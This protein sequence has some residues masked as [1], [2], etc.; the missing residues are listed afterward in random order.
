MNTLEYTAEATLG[1]IFALNQ[2]VMNITYKMDS[3]HLSM[4]IEMHTAA[5]YK[6]IDDKLHTHSEYDSEWSDKLREWE[7]KEY[8]KSCGTSRF[9][10]DT[11]IIIILY[12]QDS[13]DKLEEFIVELYKYFNMD[14]SPY[15]ETYAYIN[16]TKFINIKDI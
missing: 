15:N 12:F 1:Y 16:Y 10:G 11:A 13:K 3:F 5:D 4:Y 9:K 7:E 14:S 2:L 6:E 8:F